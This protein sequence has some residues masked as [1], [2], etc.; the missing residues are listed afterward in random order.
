MHPLCTFLMEMPRWLRLFAADEEGDCLEFADKLYIGPSI[1]NR[2]DRIVS[3]VKQGKMILSLYCITKAK[4]SIDLYDIYNYHEL[5]QSYYQKHPGDCYRSCRFERRSNRDCSTYDP[6]I[7]LNFE[8]SHMLAI[9]LFL[10]KLIGIL[11][12]VIIG[13]LLV[14]LLSI[15]FVP[16]RYRLDGTFLEEKKKGEV[17]IRWGGPFF[18]AKAGYEYGDDFF[19]FIR[20][21]GLLIFAS[22]DR[23]TVF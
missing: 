23:K 4:N 13:I 16:I 21:C 2:K 22:G 15:L 7:N 20:I 12:L 19:Y 3:R 10:L 9:L 6:E 14:I 8:E 11:L 5:R 17:Q 1:R 18:L